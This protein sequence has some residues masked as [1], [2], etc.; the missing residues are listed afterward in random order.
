MFISI[1]VQVSVSNLKKLYLSGWHGSCIAKQQT[2]CTTIRCCN[3]INDILCTIEL[4]LYTKRTTNN[5]NY[6]SLY[7]SYYLTW[8]YTAKLWFFLPRKR[9]NRWYVYF[10]YSVIRTRFLRTILSKNI[11]QSIGSVCTR[12]WLTFDK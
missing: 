9:L 7:T 8:Q 4:K 12:L 10:A 5:N 11:Q 6:W 3:C 2:H 1:V